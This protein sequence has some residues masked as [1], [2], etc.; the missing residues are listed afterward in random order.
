MMTMVAYNNDSR[1]V[2]LHDFMNM[3]NANLYS[4]DYQGEKCALATAM[5]KVTWKL[6]KNSI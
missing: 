6:Q 5:E 3:Q 4:Y 2:I 1:L